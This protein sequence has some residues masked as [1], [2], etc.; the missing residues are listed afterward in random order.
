MKATVI[1]PEN[2]G[3]FA[4]SRESLSPDLRW[5]ARASRGNEGGTL[6]TRSLW[7]GHRKSLSHDCSSAERL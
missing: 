6:A 1:L 5:R 2:I 3:S 4:V 7:P